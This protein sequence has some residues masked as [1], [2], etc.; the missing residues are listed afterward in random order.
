MAKGLCFFVGVVG[1]GRMFSGVFV[2]FWFGWVWF[3]VVFVVV[4]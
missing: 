3:E 4:L 2:D 1:W